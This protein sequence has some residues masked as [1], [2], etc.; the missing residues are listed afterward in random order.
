MASKLEE[1]RKN[2]LGA[3]LPT[4]A[5]QPS[6]PVLSVRSPLANSASTPEAPAQEVK[7]S[8]PEPH[9]SGEP[10]SIGEVAGAVDKIFEPARV[11][12]ER[13][14]E[15][16]KSF[17][18]LEHMTQ[19]AATALEPIEALY[20][21]MRKLSETFDSMRTFER[22]LATMATSFTPMQELHGGV[23]Q[24]I[25]SFYE[26]CAL[27]VQLFEP[28]KACKRRMAEL[29]SAF[30]AAGD[31]QARFYDLSQKFRPLES[32]SAR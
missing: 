11:C 25:R 31:L 1:L 12:R 16:A 28:A 29:S 5:T 17:E 3:A 22:E 23:A 7:A 18:S 6:Q 8:G 26:Q 9:S 15:L 19:W 27:M 32:N 4:L 14:T 24:L 10:Q 13:W 30:D 20:E 2:L 21:R